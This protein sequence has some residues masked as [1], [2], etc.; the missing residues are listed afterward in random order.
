MNRALAD[1]LEQR[2][3]CLNRG[4]VLLAMSAEH[5]AV[6]LREVTDR[7]LDC[8]LLRNRG[9]LM[10]LPAGVSKGSGLLAALELFGLSAHNTIAVGDAE[11]DHAMFDVAE[12]AVATANAVPSVKEHADLVLEEPN[13][14]GVI[15]LLGGPIMDGEQG[16]LSATRVRVGAFADGSPTLLPSTC[17]TVMI[18]GGSGR[19]KSY[20]AGVVTEQLLDAGYQVLVVDPRVSSL[21]W[22]ICRTW[23]SCRRPTAPRPTRS[24]ND[25]G[26]ATAWCWTSRPSAHLT[27]MQLLRD[28][29]ALVVE[30][31]AESGVPHWIVVDEAHTLIGVDGPL[32][33][34]F[35]PTAG[36]HLFVSYHPERLCPEVLSGVDVVLSASPPIDQLIDTENLPASSLPRAAFGQAQLLR[37]DRAD[38]ARPF[39]VAAR[40]TAHQRHQR[41]YA[42]MTLPQG[43]GFRFRSSAEHQLPE[44]LSMEQFQSQLHQVSPDTLAWHLRRGDLS[45]WFGEVLQD[46]ELGQVHVRM[47]NG[48]SCM[49]NNCRCCAAGM[50]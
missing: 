14:A 7:G 41:K 33:G 4:E 50:M 48:T 46:R 11:N 18:V 38:T 31:R 23:R 43:K 2:G 34:V 28:L 30:L 32:R 20:L 27:R 19:G 13:G 10:V 1:S 8:V 36:G 35:D 42:H 49:N 9:E 21:P 3:V 16:A 47:W 29:A 22:V 26:A 45:R 39:T 24:R 6:V 17:A 5:D 44:A 40:I 12:F 25:C 37:S 15:G